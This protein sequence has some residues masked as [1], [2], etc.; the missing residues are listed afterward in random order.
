MNRWHVLLA[1]ALA[2]C[3]GSSSGSDGGPRDSSDSDTG[4]ASDAD[5]DGDSD[6]DSDADSDTQAACPAATVGKALGRESFMIG[7]AMTDASLATA[8]FDIR[9][10]YLAGNV[11]AS[12]P[13][14][15]CASGCV[16]DGQSCANTAGCSWWGCWQYDQD[17]P[18]RFV[19]DFMEKTHAAGAVPML[20]YY[21]WFSV[22]GNLEG[23]PE[24]AALADGARLSAYLADFRF[25]CETV[26]EA[27]D[28]PVV[29]HLEPD[30]W[31]YGQQVDADPS[32]IPT[33]L[34]SA[35][36]PEC[37]GMAA[38][39]AGF[40]SCLR[41]IAAVEA[42]N[43]LV[44]FH[45]S[46]WGAGADALV[47]ADP[48]FDVEGHAASTAAFLTALGAADADLI[49]VEMS[50][51]DAAY[52]DRWW[53]AT[54][55]VLPHFAQA[56]A[57]TKALGEALGLAPLWWQAPYG[58]MG[59]PNVCDRYEDNRVDYVFD[60]ADAFAAAG[61]LGVAFGAG[62]DCMTTAETDDGHFLA[63]AAGYYAAPRPPL[64]GE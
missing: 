37:S 29:L 55:A 39:L 49:T 47:N 20:T 27:P 35:G 36:E 60:H 52:N 11:P 13:C 16:V 24:I 61:A 50:D 51:R 64:C 28:I 23:A 15:S 17:P 53:D 62:M 45:A 41:A 32:S 26:A 25:M 14:D 63:R 57:W 34:D 44:A 12:G 56:I 10:Q 43:A 9:Y 38:T 2:G 42:P 19:V 40:A 22:A 7:G 46:A 18:G 5:S 8:P 21:I 3:T 1:A 4:S 30:L 59:L 58:H 33:A 54:D 48:G 31:G 6:V